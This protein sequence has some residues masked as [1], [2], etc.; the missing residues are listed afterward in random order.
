M[1]LLGKTSKDLRSLLE[2]FIVS[3]FEILSTARVS[4]E[5]FPVLAIDLEIDDAS[6]QKDR[7]W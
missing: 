3:S 6:Q 4:V 5:Y 1:T 2:L 7:T